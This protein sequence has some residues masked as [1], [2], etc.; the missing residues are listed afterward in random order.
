MIKNDGYYSELIF[1]KD[2][3]SNQE[4]HTKRRTSR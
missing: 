1:T 3:L 2:K 4:N